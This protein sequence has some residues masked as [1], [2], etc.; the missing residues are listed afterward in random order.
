[1]LKER[2]QVFVGLFV[3]AD[4]L[5]LAATWAL[6]YALRFVAPLIPVTKGTPPPSDYLLLLPVIWA[7][8]GIVFRAT[9]LYDPMR[10]RPESSERRQ[11]L[12]ASSLA[13]LIFTA[14][15]FLG[16]EKAYSL[17]RL[18]LLYFYVLATSAIILERAAVREVLREARRR[19]HNLRHVLIVGDG[20]L[21]RGVAE[22]MARHPELGLKVAGF[23]T[24]DPT[25]VGSSLATIPILGV[26][27]EV[28][29]IVSAGGIDQVVMALPFERLPHLDD[30]I[31]RLDSDVVDV[32]VVP[33]VGRFVSLRS[34]IE[35]LDGL[36]VISLRATPLAGWGR[37]AKRVMDVGFALLALVFVV[38]LMVVIAVL[39]KLT[40]AGPVF[41]SQER[42]GLDGRVFRVW[43]FRTMRS[44]AEAES[45]PVWAVRD[46]P[47][48]TGLGSWLRRHSLDELP[49]LLNVLRGEMSL[50]G[51][52][53]ERPVFIDEFRRRIPR[54]MLRHMV[55]A[56]MTGWAQVHGW[57]GNT[58]IEKRIQYDLYY[59]ENWSLRLDLKI[60]LLTF[61]RGFVDRNAY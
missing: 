49:Q 34:G 8:W 12:R 16:F 4:L 24:D 6:A 29:E 17:S 46:D 28:S 25:R 15:S 2:H 35:D 57:R 30:L 22:R 14:V 56:G 53:P 47:R 31:G 50:V 21:A 3:A 10:G 11:I 55:A 58:P 36:P 41:F 27:D 61:V 54:Y 60:L 5:V 44:D 43:K 48:R 13:M 23:L 1:V 39:V 33:D 32:K 19:G 52:R 20:D 38:P 59:V 9:G 40:S 18:M 7:I 42:M 45:G 37:V 51:P 26:W